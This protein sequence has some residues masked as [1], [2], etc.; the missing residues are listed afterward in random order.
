[1]TAEVLLIWLPAAIVAT[2]AL[3]RRRRSP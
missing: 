3:T 2:V 1:V